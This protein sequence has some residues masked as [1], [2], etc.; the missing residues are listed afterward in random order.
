MLSEFMDLRSETRTMTRTHYDNR[1]EHK[2]RGRDEEESGRRVDQ[3]RAH[4]SE[5][6]PAIQHYNRRPNMFRSEPEPIPTTSGTPVS[7]THLDVYKRQAV[8]SII[9]S[10]IMRKKPKI[11]IHTQKHHMKI[12]NKNV[13]AHIRILM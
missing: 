11:Y 8:H 2:P 6:R 13:I 9:K 5:S 1:R 4:E 10:L 7:Y 12:E 3:E